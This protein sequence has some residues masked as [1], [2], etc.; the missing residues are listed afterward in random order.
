MAVLPFFMPS[1]GIG[2]E[3]AEI[4]RIVSLAADLQGYRAGL[5][6][7]DRQ[8]A[9]APLLSNWLP[10]SEGEDNWRFVGEVSDIVGRNPAQG[11]T[12]VVRALG[13]SMRWARCDERLWRLGP[14]IPIEDRDYGDRDFED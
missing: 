3:S 14:K 12:G 11:S 10:R 4:D 1:V 5:A 6:P 8:L 2:E 13:F 7:T 9:E